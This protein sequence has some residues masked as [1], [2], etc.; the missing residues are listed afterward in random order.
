MVASKNQVSRQA[1]NSLTTADGLDTLNIAAL[2]YRLDA[3]V[4]YTFVRW[5]GEEFLMILPGIDRFSAQATLN[6]LIERLC[7]HPLS[8]HGLQVS[9]SAGVGEHHHQTSKGLL[10]EIDQVLYQA[11]S[12]GRSCVAIAPV[13]T[14]HPREHLDQT[15]SS[16]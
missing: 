4:P 1:V 2:I 14:F 7:H 12:A 6:R 10:E 16:L 3:G 5:G 8:R 11:K 13:P 15:L 9:F